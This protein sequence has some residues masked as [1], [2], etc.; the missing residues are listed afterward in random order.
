MVST[1]GVLLVRDLPYH[2][3]PEEIEGRVRKHLE[4]PGYHC[5]VKVLGLESQGGGRPGG[6]IRQA[7]VLYS[8]TPLL[9]TV[10]DDDDEETTTF[11]PYD[12]SHPRSYRDAALAP[13]NSFGFEDQVIK[14]RALTKPKSLSS[15]ADRMSDSTLQSTLPNCSGS[16]AKE[17]LPVKPVQDA[18]NLPG[19]VNT[20][21]AGQMVVQP[22][23]W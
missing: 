4:K 17:Y 2:T 3:H 1:E 19:V 9:D 12:A 11:S 21:N 22:G 5:S 15:L 10:D 6:D 23:D 18:A 16:S 7:E 8:Y 13:V 20:G 14:A